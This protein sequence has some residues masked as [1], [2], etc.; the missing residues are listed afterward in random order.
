M[1]LFGELKVNSKRNLEREKHPLEI[2]SLP[3]AYPLRPKPHLIIIIPRREHCCSHLAGE[4][5]EAQETWYSSL[6]SSLSSPH[7]LPHDPINLFKILIIPCS[8]SSQGSTDPP[9]CLLRCSLSLTHISC[10]G[11][12]AGFCPSSCN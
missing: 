8:L 12:V 2:C 9:V 6:R 1:Q 4:E 5:T 3:G 7:Y 11:C 10:I